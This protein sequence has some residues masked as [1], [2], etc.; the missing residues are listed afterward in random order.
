MWNIS[1]HSAAVFCF[2]PQPTLPP[3]AV[4]RQW[5]INTCHKAVCKPVKSDHSCI[6]VELLPLSPWTHLMT[7][8]A[9]QVCEHW[10]W[11]YH[12]TLA[13]GPLSGT[14]A[15][16][17]NEFV[18]KWAD[19]VQHFCVYRIR[20]ACCELV[21]GDCPILNDP[22]LDRIS[23]IK[24]YHKDVDPACWWKCMHISM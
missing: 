1:W 13:C 7:R 24:T 18:E 20:G 8:F 22:I 23:A 16:A 5:M 12:I 21:Y 10:N 19:V 9:R 17:W 15:A 14:D 6:M 11:K 3:I 4:H 2:P